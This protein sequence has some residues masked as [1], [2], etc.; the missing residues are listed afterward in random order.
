MDG[1]YRKIQPAKVGRPGHPF[2]YPEFVAGTAGFVF[3]KR[4]FSAGLRHQ[5]RRRRL[6]SSS[7]ATIGMGCRIDP[8]P[9]HYRARCTA[10]G[11]RNSRP[12]CRR[13]AKVVRL[14]AARY[15][16]PPPRLRLWASILWHH[17]RMQPEN[18][19]SQL[20]SYNGRT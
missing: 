10:A 13:P 19:M 20:R 14:R 16:P 9:C 8:W 11:R 3:I 4:T 1:H 2:A 18:L 6:E 17:P 15:E 5:S 12:R 7:I